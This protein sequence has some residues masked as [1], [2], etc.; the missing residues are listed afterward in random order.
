MLRMG[1]TVMQE[2]FL[3][4]YFHIG[5]YSTVFFLQRLQYMRLVKYQGSHGHDISGKVLKS[6]NT[7]SSA[8]KVLEWSKS[9]S[10]SWKVL[11]FFVYA[12]FLAIDVVGKKYIYISITYTKYVTKLPLKIADRQAHHATQR[13]FSKS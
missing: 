5:T 7:F 8:G 12:L 4:P 1:Q 13:V 2:K 10:R 3:F 6:E 9:W 11:E